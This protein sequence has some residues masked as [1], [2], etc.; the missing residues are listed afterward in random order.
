[1]LG[2]FALAAPRWGAPCP[3][4]AHSLLA[5]P[6]RRMPLPGNKAKR[7]SH[8]GSALGFNFFL[9]FFFSLWASFGLV[10]GQGEVGEGRNI[11]P[12]LAK[13][14]PFESHTPFPRAAV[15]QWRSFPNSPL[16]G[17][18]EGSRTTACWW[19]GC[20]KCASNP[21]LGESCAAGQDRFPG[22]YPGERQ[23]L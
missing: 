2:F 17:R 6:S 3:P 16:H 22:S 11:D 7:P 5:P 10:P 20:R 12:R 15:A 21:W 8:S 19:G 23:P 13:T 1:M 4:P 18:R 14:S 9:S